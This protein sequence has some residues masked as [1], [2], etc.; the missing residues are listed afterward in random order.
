M[1]SR[2][3]AYCRVSCD[4]QAESGAGIA[5]QVKVLEDYCLKSGRTIYKFYKD[6]G[7]SGS[8]M[9]K[10]VQLAQLLNDIQKDD[11]LLVSRRDRLARSVELLC[12]IDREIKTKQAVII[13]CDNDTINNDD[14]SSKLFRTVLDAI[15]QFER[16]I[17][18][19]RTKAALQALKS[20]KKRT[21]KIPWG[22]R[23][24]NDRLVVDN[25][26]QFITNHIF[27]L[28]EQGLTCYKIAQE[29]N[30]QKYKRRYANPWTHRHV[31][32]IIEN[33]PKHKCLR[34]E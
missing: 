3:L 30:E 25:Y 7:V 20:Q 10:R 17:G 5:A 11:I 21:G 9:N 22:H 16:D 29:L 8:S 32:T 19:S 15:S 1:T 34:D 14:P 12:L 23:L 18:A 13:S 24:E 27:K 31:Q 33:Y 28:K 6:E 4:D 2:V 26:E